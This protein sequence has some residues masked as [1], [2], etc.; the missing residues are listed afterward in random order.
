[1]LYVELCAPQKYEVLTASTLQ[2]GNRVF[3]YIISEDEILLSKAVP[4]EQKRHR[5]TRGEYPMTM[6]ANRRAT[7]IRQVPGMDGHQQI[8][9]IGKEGFYPEAQSMAL[10][11]L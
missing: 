8:L 7:A 11:I 2:F 3:V 1:M 6:E 4:E 5:N 10:L 9:G